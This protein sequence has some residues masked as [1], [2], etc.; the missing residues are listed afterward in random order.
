MKFWIWFWTF[1]IWTCDK[2]DQ[3]L[4]L[5]Y[6]K[7]AQQIIWPGLFFL[8][9]MTP[10]SC[11]F[12]DYLNERFALCITYSG[13]PYS[14]FPKLYLS[15]FHAVARPK[16]FDK[17]ASCHL[18]DHIVSEFLLVCNIYE[19]QEMKCYRSKVW[20]EKN[21]TFTK[22]SKNILKRSNRSIFITYYFCA[23]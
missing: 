9:F 12:F 1:P 16:I 15:T 18:Y 20:V 3:K 6:Y 10:V 14:H 11:L 19:W 21:R 13:L 5:P 7:Y 4:I 17:A 2:F 23:A 22:L 8:K